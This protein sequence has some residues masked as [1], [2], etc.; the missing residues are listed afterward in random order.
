MLDNLLLGLHA[1]LDWY[2]LG[3]MFVGT[4]AGMLVGI[5]P[6]L[7]PM[8]AMALLIPLTFTMDPLA[9]LLM[10]ASIAAAANCSGSFTSILLN[11][12]GETTSA[13]TCFDGHPMARQGKAAIAIGLSV[14]ASFVAAVIGVLIVIVLAA[15]LVSL[16]LSFGPPE[17]FA[18]AVL[19]ISLVSALSEGAVVKGLM[20]GCLGLTLSFV[21]VDAVIGEPRYTFGVLALQDG[22]SLVAVM[23]GLFAI[24]EIMVWI[25]E[26]GT[27]SKVATLQGSIW[28]GVVQTFR[29]PITLLRSTFIGAAFG[30][31]PG[32]GA[33]A[34]TF[35]SYGLERR[36]AKDP[37]RF[38]NGAPEGVIAP[39]AANNSS[40]V[41]SLIPAL[42]LGVP[43]GAVSAL[44]LV[45]LMVHGIRP[46]ALLFSHQPELVY[47]FLVGLLFG[48]VQFL[49]VS[50]L[51]AD[52][53]ARI[54]LVRAEILAPVFLVLSLAGV[55]AQD[56]HIFDVYVAIAFGILGYVARA[57]G[58]P[59]VPL[60]LGLV[61]GKMGETSFQQALTIS[62]GDPLILISRPISGTIIVASVMLPFAGTIMKLMMKF[63]RGRR[64]DEA[65]K[66]P[67]IQ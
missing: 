12:P 23:I 19:G 38:G 15:P 49:V 48:A 18:L 52:F 62:A 36:A 63:A 65:L 47:G 56:Q 7:G 22:V 64:P 45:A 30:A 58:Y 59:L 27:V 28:E 11:V 9:A 8:T 66:P 43:G 32:V 5:I 10:L 2:R 54:T 50:I 35:L 61:L 31:I 44:L 6:G 29:Y 3:M 21:G 16:A 55:Y 24:T 51:L 42:T 13:A 20:M 46:G 37:S 17:Y 14:G 1:V 39:E 41:T 26:G 25:N 40:I 60:V 33:V 34:A 53:F 4:M 67:P 57:Y